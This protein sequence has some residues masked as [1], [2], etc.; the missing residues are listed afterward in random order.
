MNLPNEVEIV[1]VFDVIDNPTPMRRG[2][3]VYLGHGLLA[4]FESIALPLLTRF[5]LRTRS[6]AIRPWSPVVTI[7][8]LGRHSSLLPRLLYHKVS[9]FIFV[10][11]KSYDL[12]C[13]R[14]ADKVQLGQ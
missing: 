6:L 7:A 3:K 14:R 8:S 10:T 1:V 12:V 11:R 9:V 4:F 13:L 5:A 2:H